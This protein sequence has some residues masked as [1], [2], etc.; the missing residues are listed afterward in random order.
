ME[1]MLVVGIIIGI[2]A[3]TSTIS[4]GDRKRQGIVIQYSRTVD[5]LPAVNEA[6]L[7]DS[8]IVNVNNSTMQVVEN[9]NVQVSK[10]DISEEEEGE[11]GDDPSSI[12][13]IYLIRPSSST[14]LSSQSSTT[15]TT[16]TST[17]ASTPFEFAQISWEHLSKAWNRTTNYH[18][19]F[20]LSGI[21][22]S[23]IDLRHDLSGGKI[24]GDFFVNF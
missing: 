11:N 20:P 24:G 8:I 18:D 15:N 22:S 5:R 12:L 4:G 6:M 19:L 23:S 2:V 21:R 7:N 9:D 1:I 17:Y 3:Y 16:A 13:P 10:D 14:A